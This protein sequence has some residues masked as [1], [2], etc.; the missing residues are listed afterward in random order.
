MYKQRISH[1][2]AVFGICSM[3]FMQ[4]QSVLAESFSD[5]WVLYKKGEYAEAYKIF[6]DLAKKSNS[7]AQT[8]LG[9]MYA[10]G[11][12]VPKDY[13]ASALWLER[14]AVRHHAHAQLNLG[15]LY[16][17]GQGVKRDKGIARYW[18]GRSAE[19]GNGL[20]ML[21]LGVL[22]A[23]GATWGPSDHRIEAYK[24]FAVALSKFSTSDKHRMTASENLQNLREL[25]TEVQISK[26]KRL[27]QE[28][29]KAH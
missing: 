21:R 20:A 13:V 19:Q 27:A 12:G 2:C 24:W 4:G 9:Q 10:T 6:L 18:W 5:G 22:L 28:W 23:Y 1:I 11:R 8:A 17:N 25:M 15:G 26:G 16:H 3:L 7:D 29:I 14:A